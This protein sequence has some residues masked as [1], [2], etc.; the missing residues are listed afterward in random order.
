MTFIL[1][2]L[3]LTLFIVGYAWMLAEAFKVSLLWGLAVLLPPIAVVFGAWH[4]RE[5][6]RPLL[7]MGLGVGIF[8]G[9]MPGWGQ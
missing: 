3:A 8:L 1:F 5:Q 2:Y 6:W 7:L 9:L 4:A